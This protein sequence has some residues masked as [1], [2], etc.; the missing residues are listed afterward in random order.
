MWEKCVLYL[1]AFCFLFSCLRQKENLSEQKDDLTTIDSTEDFFEHKVVPQHAKHFTVSYHGNYKVIKTDATFYLGNEETEGK[2]KNDVAVLVQKGTTPPPLEGPLENAEILFIPVETVALNEHHAECFLRELGLENRI[3]VIGGPYSYN[4][5]MR[6]K[7]FSGEIG[8]IGYSWH[9]APNIEVLLERKPEL[10]INTL[11]SMDHSPGLE[12]C[13]QLG[14]PTATAFDWA[15]EEYLGRAEWI[16]FYSLFF[17][18]EQEANRVFQDIQQRIETLKVMTANVPDKPKAMWG[19][20]IGKQ[21]WYMQLTSYSGQYMRDAGLE[22]IL[23][24]NTKP[25]ANGAQTLS[26]EELL[27]KGKEAEHWIIGD[28]HAGNLPKD[29]LMTSFDAWRTGQLYHNMKRAN[30]KA[31]TSDWDAQAIVRPDSV[32][33]DLI[34][35]VYPDLLPGYVPVFLGHYDKSLDSDQV[36]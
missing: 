18:A 35:L 26:T 24:P 13:R 29:N 2:Q 19:F 12:K 32:L 6:D 30:L 3:N 21:R 25:N 28:I 5:E 33:A 20:Y 11:G 10:F 7:A 1:L 16:K 4:S 31:N 36:E 8:Q 9:S 23:L 27:L 14:I 17:N 15:E 22:N 34:K